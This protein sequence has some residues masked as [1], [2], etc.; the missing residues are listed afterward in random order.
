VGGNFLGDVELD[1]LI[2]RELIF[3][4]FLLIDLDEAAFFL[5][6]VSVCLL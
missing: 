1:V 5:F 6:K 4:G 3:R 2:L